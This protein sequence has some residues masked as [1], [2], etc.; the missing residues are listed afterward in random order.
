MA[1][2]DVALLANDF[3]F[4]QRT[5]GAIAQ[6][7]I[8]LGEFN[9]I[10]WATGHNWEMAGMPG[11][12]DAY[13]Y[14]VLTGIVRPGNDPAVITDAQI[15]SAIQLILSIETEPAATRDDAGIAP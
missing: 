10:G 9:A 6:E 1:Y 4:T 5:A 15:L 2:S 13:G 14:A 7:Q 12:G 8:D 11:F 3:D